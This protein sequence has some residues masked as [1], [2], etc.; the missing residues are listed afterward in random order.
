MDHKRVNEFGFSGE[1]EE[2]Q[3]QVSSGTP[4]ITDSTKGSADKKND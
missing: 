3:K 2:Q 1:M 4:A